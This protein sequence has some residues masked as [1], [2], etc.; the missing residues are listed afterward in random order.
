MSFWQEEQRSKVD[1]DRYADPAR[2]RRSLAPERSHT[3]SVVA[4]GVTEQL[5]LA[6]LTAGLDDERLF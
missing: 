2:V 4:T 5:A 3:A 1:I 6:E